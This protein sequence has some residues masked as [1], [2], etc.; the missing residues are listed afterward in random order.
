MMDLTQL[1]TLVTT[2]IG[3]GGLSAILTARITAKKADAENRRTDQETEGIR[4]QNE[5][6]E[7]DYINKRLQEITEISRK[8][9]ENLRSKNESLNEKISELNNK[10]HSLMEWIVCDNFQY[11]SWLESQLRQVKPDI[12]FPETTKPPMFNKEENTNSNND[13]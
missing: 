13:N 2:A 11:R 7:M 12:E 6:T 8:E 10:M 9:A 3:S 4:I 1:I 5:I